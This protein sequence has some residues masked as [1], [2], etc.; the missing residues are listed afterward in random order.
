MIAMIDR[1]YGNLWTNI[2]A[3]MVDSMGWKVGDTLEVSLA[4]GG[5]PQ[6]R[7]VVAPFVES[8]GHVAVGNPVTYLNSLLELAVAINQGS[9]AER[10]GVRAGPEWTIEV[11]RTGSATRP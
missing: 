7:P 8:F 1:P 6:G 3:A 11:R 2:P 4:M 10:Y 5:K 9:F